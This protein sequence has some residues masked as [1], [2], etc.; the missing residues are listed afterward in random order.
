MS[1]YIFE[2]MTQANAAAFNPQQD[3][4]LFSD[5]ANTPLSIAVTSG[6]GANQVTLT[7]ASG[8]SRTFDA[9]L[10]QDASQAGRIIFDASS[11]VIVTGTSENNLTALASGV[12][13]STSGVFHGLEGNDTINSNDSPAYAF[14]GNG[15]DV[16]NGGNGNDH[17]YG[18]GL[19]GDP[20]GDGADNIS[21]GAGS[22]YIQGN[23]GNDILSGGAGSDRIQ[24]GQGNDQIAGDGGND[25][26]NGN[27][28]DDT[29]SGG[30]GN[31]ILR[32]GQGDDRIGGGD[33]DDILFGDIGNDR[34]TGGQGF[35]VLTGGVGNDVF[36]FAN[37]DARFS[38]TGPMAFVSDRIVDFTIG[39]DKVNF[40]SIVTTVRH[41]AD[42][43]T[44]TDL[45]EATK[46]AQKVLDDANTASAGASASSVVAVQVGGDTYLF[47]NDTAIVGEINSLIRLDG[48]LAAN[49]T[50]TSIG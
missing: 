45:A 47:Y 18:F 21:G 1:L 31:D 34:L 16:I 26:V 38:A 49:F 22:D 42:G 27:K 12:A 15:N 7:T 44:V 6:P 39:E 4:I 8:L 29:V 10:L 20:S 3:N 11:S 25:V 2:T 14:G 28:G 19:A 36:V 48:V 40:S 35:D 41:V 24:G 9:G 17:L 23:A 13:A 33:G 37:L 30:D 32:G 43:V 50:A 5:R 46:A